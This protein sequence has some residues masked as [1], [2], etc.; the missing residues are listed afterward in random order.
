MP[1]NERKQETAE[2][3]ACGGYAA[4]QIQADYCDAA[5]HAVVR[6][7]TSARVFYSWQSDLPK[8]ANRNLIERAI[9]KAIKVASAELDIPARP[10]R[11]TQGHS[12]AP[13][14]VASVLAKI[15]MARVFVADA[16]PINVGKA[17]KEQRPAR[18]IRR[19]KGHRVG[20]AVE[21]LPFDI[22]HR[23]C[24]QYNS[25][26]TDTR[27]IRQNGYTVPPSSTVAVNEWREQSCSA[28]LFAAEGCRSDQL[29][30]CDPNETTG[31]K[32]DEIAH[33]AFRFAFRAPARTA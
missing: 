11:D 1:S 17:A 5:R 32:L 18:P 2:R 33:G 6:G 4:A 3:V 21:D 23:S 12:G 25:H 19:K 24:L 16:T 15:E 14:I 20:A 31:C 10:D 27:C 26:P 9:E 13:D 28:F 22:R 29:L 8:I 7:V 30:R